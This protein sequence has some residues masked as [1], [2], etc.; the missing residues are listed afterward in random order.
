MIL[1]PPI[2]LNKI[3]WYQ[4]RYL[5]HQ[6]CQEYHQR[7]IYIDDYYGGYCKCEGLHW[8][9]LNDRNLGN[10]NQ[11]VNYYNTIYCFLDGKYTTAKVP[12]YY[13]YSNGFKN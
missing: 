2:I 8:W 10:A 13:Y 5:Q 12:K 3:Y 7:F 6:L 9:A 4:W 1:F 11:Y